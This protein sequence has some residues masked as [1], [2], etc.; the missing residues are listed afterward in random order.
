MD[1]IKNTIGKSAYDAYCT[2]R[3]WKSYNGDLLPQWTDVKP[4]IQ[5]GWVTA[6]VAAVLHARAFIEESIIIDLIDNEF[7]ASAAKS[8]NQWNSAT[9]H[10]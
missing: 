6:G 7:G 5:A 1:A 3:K 9:R 10:R 4:E 2:T 8:P